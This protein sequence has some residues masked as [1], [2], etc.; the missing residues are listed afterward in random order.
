MSKNYELEFLK[1]ILKTEK[2]KELIDW[3]SQNLSIDE[4]LSKI[5]EKKKKKRPKVKAR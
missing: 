3:I 1:T 4:I 2:E 5:K